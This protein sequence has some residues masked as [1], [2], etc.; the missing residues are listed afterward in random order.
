MAATGAVFTRVSRLSRIAPAESATSWA[1]S[2]IVFSLS[3]RNG[4][5]FSAT[6]ST[7]SA[8]VWVPSATFSE[9]SWRSPA[10]LSSFLRPLDSLP[11]P[12]LAS[13]NPSA[14]SL[15]PFSALAVPVS[16]L[17]APLAALTVAPWMSEKEMKIW[18]RKDREAFVDAA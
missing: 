7:L 16:S 11:L 8:S 14:R 6:P 15:E 2:P 12:L 3:L 5:T 10:P 9:P 17:S 18:S 1:V 4:P 13:F